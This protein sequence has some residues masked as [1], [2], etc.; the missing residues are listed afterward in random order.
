MDTSSRKLD[1]R[2]T[3]HLLPVAAVFSWKETRA[4]QATS[5][6]FHRT[7]HV[8]LT[9]VNREMS[10][11][12]GAKTTLVTSWECWSFH[13]MNKA[14]KWPVGRRKQ[15]PPSD[16]EFE[17]VRGRIEAPFHPRHPAV[18]PQHVLTW[19]SF[20]KLPTGVKEGVRGC[21]VR[22]WATCVGYL[23]ITVYNLNPH[24][25]EMLEILTSDQRTNAILLISPPHGLPRPCH[26][27]SPPGF[28]G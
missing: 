13:N 25:R 16:S 7:N 12:T 17:F 20:R 11:R 4:S 14:R 6:S 21:N 5:L 24:P 15:R 27:R 2:K 10:P 19:Q 8:P 22:I 18:K 9:P 3:Y 26:R 28:H 23:D 1:D